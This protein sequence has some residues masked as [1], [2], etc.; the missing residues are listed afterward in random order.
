MTEPLPDGTCLLH[1]GPH[2]TGT[3]T[4]QSG[5]H[6]NRE[7]L[8]EQGVQYIGKHLTPMKAAVATASGRSIETASLDLG[9][10]RWRTLVGDIRASTARHTVMSSEFFADANAERVAATIDDLGLER[11]HVVVTLRPLSRILASQWQQYMQNRPSVKYDD[12]LDYVGW[13]HAVLDDPDGRAITPSFWQRHRHDLLVERWAKVVGPDRLTVVVLDESDKRMLLRSF[14]ELL[15]L[16]DGTL[17]PRD[18]GT[19]RSL[20]YPE[21]RLLCDFNRDFLAQ[22][23]GTADYNMLVRFGA[24]RHLQERVP[25]ADEP[26]LLTPQWAVD[27]S[28]EIAEGFVSAI[29]GSRVRVVG[30]LSSLA[31]PTVAVGVGDNDPTAPVPAEVEARFLAGLV[32]YVAE[33]PPFDPERSRIVGDLERV[34]RQDMKER[35]LVREAGRL[36]REIELLTAELASTPYVDELSRGK[37]LRA[38][39]GRLRRRIKPAQ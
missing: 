23:W 24:V 27:R 12:S 13:L 11:T 21:V 22:G 8:A 10:E 15:R 28:A 3:S 7:R 39:A 34:I 36:D 30:D 35:R 31:D 38:V 25:P 6:H 26:R 29:A 33:L 37:L 20:T 17:V 2:K 32:K 14:E 18:L 4:L 16:E 5:F 19:N 1:I 9:M